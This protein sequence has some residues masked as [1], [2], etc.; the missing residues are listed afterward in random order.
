MQ[1]ICTTNV[2]VQ[3]DIGNKSGILSISYLHQSMK[4]PKVFF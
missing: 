2:Y 3:N 1:N 4:K